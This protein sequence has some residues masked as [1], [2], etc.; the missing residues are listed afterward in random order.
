[1]TWTIGSVA[2][3]ATGSVTL[4]VTVSG[5]ID[6]CVICNTAQI[7]SPVQNGGTAVNSDQVCVAA[8]PAPDASTAKASG[9]AIGL[10][11]YVPALGIPLVNTEISKA[12]SSQT[13]PGQAADDEE[14]LSLDILGA[15][16]LASIAKASVLRST[17][18]P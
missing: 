8:S 14:L 17:H 18:R 3:G 10:K 13:G 16:G 12:G 2:P 5:A 11:A 4:T 1:M 7:K 9:E 6:E 15:V